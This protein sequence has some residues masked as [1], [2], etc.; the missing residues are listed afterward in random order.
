MLMLLRATATVA[1]MF[2][3]KQPLRVVWTIATSGE[4]GDGLTMEKKAMI[5]VGG[6]GGNLGLLAYLTLEMP[7]HP[8]HR[9]PLSSSSPSLLHHWCDV[10]VVLGMAKMWMCCLFSSMSIRAPVAPT[11]TTVMW[12]LRAGRPTPM[13]LGLA[14]VCSS[15]RTNP[16]PDFYQRPS[17]FVT[18]A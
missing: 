11:A 16:E 4:D 1:A 14:I 3:E 2:V 6:D 12:C 15:A 18:P 13:G 5:V 10:D 8:F 7:N 9:P 17:P